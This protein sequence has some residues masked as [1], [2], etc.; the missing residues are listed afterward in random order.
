MRNGR[1][2]RSRI[3]AA[4]LSR[5]MGRKDLLE[6]RGFPGLG[7]GIIMACFQMAGKVAELMDWLKISVR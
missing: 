2:S 6:S 1:S 3:L 7:I 4:G 5:E